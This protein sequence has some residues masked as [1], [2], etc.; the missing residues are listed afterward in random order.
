MKCG[1]PK[2]DRIET[3][4]EKVNLQTRGPAFFKLESVR[5]ETIGK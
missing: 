5:S 3:D 1:W 2:L 4:C